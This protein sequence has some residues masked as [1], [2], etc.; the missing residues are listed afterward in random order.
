M[1][2]YSVCFRCGICDKEF[3]SKNSL[4]QHKQ[5]HS[6]LRNFQCMYCMKQFQRKGTLTIHIR[7]HTGEKR[8]ACDICDRRFVQKNDMLKHQK[9]HQSPSLA[10]KSSSIT[11]SNDDCVLEQQYLCELCSTLYQSKNELN[12]HRLIIHGITIPVVFNANN[13]DVLTTI[14]EIISDESQN[15]LLSNVP[16]YSD[17]NDIIK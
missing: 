4:N 6:T 16:S 12:E 10:N 9:T 2:T 5:R 7:T 8:Y 15:I 14:T 17:S 1:V 13:S 11:K 3:S